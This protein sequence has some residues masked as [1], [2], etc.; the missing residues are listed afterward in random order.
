VTLAAVDAD[1]VRATSQMEAAIVASVHA[2]VIATAT[3]R[4]LSTR[5]VTELAMPY[6]VLPG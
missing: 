6:D 3:R 4:Q 1:P 5:A 2:L